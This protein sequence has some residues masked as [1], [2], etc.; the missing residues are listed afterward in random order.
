MRLQAAL[1]LIVDGLPGCRTRT[2]ILLPHVA[3]R[4]E[5]RYM[6]DLGV[7]QLFQ[8]VSFL[9]NIQVRI[10]CVICDDTPAV[11]EVDELCVQVPFLPTYE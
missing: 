2:C 3:V 7:V 6:L 11:L 4:Y 5:R 1:E 8:G 9:P 10:G